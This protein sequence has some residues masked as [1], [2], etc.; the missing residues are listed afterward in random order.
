LAGL[1]FHR[2]LLRFHL[3]SNADA[4]LMSR[5]L[6]VHRLSQ[7]LDEGRATWNVFGKKADVWQTPGGDF[8]AALDSAT[9]PIGT[10]TGNV[11]FDVTVA[12][13]KL[14]GASAIPLSLLVR[15]ASATGPVAELAFTSTEGNAS[16][17][18]ELSLEYCDP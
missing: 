12:V 2:A 15:E 14:L 7:P 18:P 1:Q 17:I 16:E 13:G 4:G 5:R 6:T 9:V 8:G 10:A 3:E 11:D